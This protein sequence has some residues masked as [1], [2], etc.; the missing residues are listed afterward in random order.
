MVK[1]VM[2]R[3][4]AALSL[5]V[6]A[7]ACAQGKSAPA[8]NGHP[9]APSAPLTDTQLSARLL[10]AGD[11]SDAAWHVTAFPAPSGPSDTAPS[12]GSSST[13]AF[14][15]SAMID[16]LTFLKSAGSP[17]AA[18]SEMIGGR[19]GAATPAGT[20][21]R[22]GIQGTELLYSYA[23]EGARQAMAKVRELVGRCSAPQNSTDM[24]V[25]FSLAAAAAAAQA[26]APALGDESLMVRTAN[27]LDGGLARFVSDTL[28][29]R[30]GSTVM[31]LTTLQ[32][33]E[34]NAAIMSSSLGAVALKK[35]Q[36]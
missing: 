16:G 18:A 34:H 5:M 2:I 27:D 3:T 28:I 19:G 7:G 22:S 30:S 14:D 20:I 12:A 11:V 24:T 10:A 35:L 25:T 21:D 17:A 13:E 8:A 1:N 32:T 9:S 6:A 23:G 15:C 26:Q 33:T 31:V 29:V 4:V 36:S